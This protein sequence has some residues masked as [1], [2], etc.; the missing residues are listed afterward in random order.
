M[1]TKLC[2]LIFSHSKLKREIVLLLLVSAYLVDSCSF[3]LR[4]ET[5][6]SREGGCTKL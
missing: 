5:V 4:N 6:G 1:V 2:R 3:N